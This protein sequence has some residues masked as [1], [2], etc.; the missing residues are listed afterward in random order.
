MERLLLGDAEAMRHYLRVANLGVGL[1]WMAEGESGQ[2]A[3]DGKSEVRNPKAEIFDPQ[4]PIPDPVS[5][6]PPIILDLSPPLSLSPLLVGG[7]LF[8]YTM[9]ALIVGIALLIGWTWRSPHRQQVAGKPRRRE[10]SGERDACAG[11]AVGRPDHRHGRLP[12]GR[13]RH[14]HGGPGDRVPLGRKYALA[15][16]YMEITYDT[17]AKVILQG[18]ATYEVESAHG[19]FL[20]LGKLTARVEKNDERQSDE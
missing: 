2:W 12:V 3:A 15:S 6:I 20:S 1:R 17:G 11:G 8:S 14:G 7:F 10:V 5:S 19:G 4:S 16:G 18:P 13:S 9:S